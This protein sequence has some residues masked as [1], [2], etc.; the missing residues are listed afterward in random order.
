VHARGLRAPVVGPVTLIIMRRAGTDT[1]GTATLMELAGLLEREL[2]HEVHLGLT[3]QNRY[4]YR[5]RRSRIGD[6]TVD[7]KRVHDLSHGTDFWFLRAIAKRTAWIGR[8]RASRSHSPVA[9]QQERTDSSSRRPARATGQAAQPP[10]GQRAVRVASYLLGSGRAR[11]A[12]GSTDLVVWSAGASSSLQ[13][14]AVRQHTGAPIVLNHNGSAGQ[15]LARLASRTADERERAQGYVD[16][17]HQ[18]DGVVFQ[19]E[20]HEAVARAHG[21]RAAHFVISPSCDE[22]AAQEAANTPPPFDTGRMNVVQVASVQERKGQQDTVRAFAAIADRHPSAVLHLVGA[23]RD[24][25]AGKAYEREL[26]S[27]VDRNGFSER[28]VMHGHRDDH[29]RFLAH[30]TVVVQASREEGVSRALREAMFLARPVVVLDI[31]GVRD[32]VDEGR[33]GLLAPAG[34]VDA[35]ARALDRVLADEDLREALGRSAHGRYVRICSRAEYVEGWRSLITRTQ[36]S[37]ARPSGSRAL[38]DRARAAPQGVD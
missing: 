9:G 26:R 5:V 25:H 4:A 14:D 8:E 32:I 19:S 22:V 29:L 35:L 11:R 36:A 21:S 33:S 6:V 2:G 1:G 13:V 31:T 16:Y 24:G 20:A 23:T 10:L 30:A 3:R 12:L 28:V 34:D 37:A 18:F 27:F 15:F 38:Q 17:L 7:P